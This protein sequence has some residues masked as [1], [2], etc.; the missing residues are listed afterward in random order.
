MKIAE[1]KWRAQLEEM[2]LEATSNATLLVQSVLLCSCKRVK[3][4]TGDDVADVLD[5]ANIIFKKLSDP[6]DEYTLDSI[7]K[8]LLEINVEVTEEWK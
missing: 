4:F 2:K 7:H 6:D 8:E 3:G 5:E 1:A